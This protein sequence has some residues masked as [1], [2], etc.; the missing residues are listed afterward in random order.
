MVEILYDWRSLEIV[1]IPLAVTIVV[2]LFLYF[3]RVFILIFKLKSVNDTI[4]WNLL[5]YSIVKIQ[6]MLL[7]KNKSQ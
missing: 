1:S 7:I 4:K 3:S 6:T 5:C 2:Y